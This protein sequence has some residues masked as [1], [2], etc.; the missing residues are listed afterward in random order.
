MKI[1]YKNLCTL[2]NFIQTTNWRYQSFTALVLSSILSLGMSLIVLDTV[3]AS[4]SEGFHSDPF[5][6]I[7]GKPDRDDKG[8]RKTKHQNLNIHHLPAKL[9]NAVLREVSRQTRIPARNLRVTH[10]S[11]KTWPNGCLGLPK[12]GEFC[13]EAIVKGWSIVL[14]NSRKTWVYRTD[15]SGRILRLEN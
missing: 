11:Q 6:L 10:Y 15:N 12:P 4:P 2:V 14:S 9:A 7:K 3:A 8:D 13:T 5:E 1:I